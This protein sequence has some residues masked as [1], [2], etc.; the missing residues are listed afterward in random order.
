MPKIAIVT[1]TDASLSHEVAGKYGSSLR[2]TKWPLRLV[3]T[4]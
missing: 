1:D 3:P 2:L 4:R